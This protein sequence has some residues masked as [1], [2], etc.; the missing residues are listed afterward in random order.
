MNMETP[1][2]ILTD[3]DAAVMTFAELAQ[4]RAEIRA[5]EARVTAQ[6]LVV[7]WRYSPALADTRWWAVMPEA[8]VEEEVAA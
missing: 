4:Q 2:F 1:A 8:V 6:G 5:W 3:R 7:T